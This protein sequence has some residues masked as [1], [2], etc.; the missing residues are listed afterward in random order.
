MKAIFEGGRSWRVHS[1]G[2]VRVAVDPAW[3]DDVGWTDSYRYAFHPPRRIDHRTAPP[4]DAVVITGAHPEQLDLQTLHQLDRRVVVMVSPLLPAVAAEAIEVLGFIAM[5]GYVDHD[6]SV[7]DLV[8]RFVAPA[9]VSTAALPTAGLM[10][11]ESGHPSVFYLRGDGPCRADEVPPDEGSVFEVCHDGAAR[12]PTSRGEG[13]HLGSGVRHPAV[14]RSLLGGWVTQRSEPMAAA[15][16]AV[17]AGDAWD[18][19]VAVKPATAAE[20][21]SPG[22][23]EE[24]GE[25][26]LPLS[27]PTRSDG[28][29][30]DRHQLVLDELPAL[31]RDLTLYPPGGPRR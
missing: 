17:R 22:R 11:R 20:W 1:T 25:L 31:A 12:T 13:L 29:G 16:H 15:P 14:D 8:L 26:T 6:I 19:G 7:G 4:V 21:V 3:L 9:P 2:G 27:A 18:V 5:R 23:E 30:R 28:E 10:V 24:P